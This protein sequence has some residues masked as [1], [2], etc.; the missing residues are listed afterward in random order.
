[1]I[2]LY[3]AM[4]L[5]VDRSVVPPKEMRRSLE[6]RTQPEPPRPLGFDLQAPSK[7]RKKAVGGREGTSELGS[8]TGARDPVTTGEVVTVGFE[9]DGERGGDGGM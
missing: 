3:S 8:S 7:P 1:M 2:P 5:V 4:L 9:G 6:V